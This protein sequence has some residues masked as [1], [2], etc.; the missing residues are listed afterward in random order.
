MGAAN[1]TLVLQQTTAHTHFI[2]CFIVVPIAE[3]FRE[4]VGLL[5][6]DTWLGLQLCTNVGMN[7]TLSFEFV[8]ARAI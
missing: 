4:G 5:Q 7:R 3:H 2:V 1:S 6:F 8:H